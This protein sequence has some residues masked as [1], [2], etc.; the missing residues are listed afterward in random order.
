MKIKTDEEYLECVK[1]VTFYEN[2][3][4]YNCDSWQDLADRGFKGLALERLHK[5]ACGRYDYAECLEEVSDYMIK[6][7]IKNIREV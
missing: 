4:N 7:N 1:A 3:A 6:H 5:D 2:K